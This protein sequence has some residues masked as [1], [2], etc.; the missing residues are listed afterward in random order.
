MSDITAKYE[1]VIGLEIHIQLRTE[2]KMFCSCENK[3]FATEPNTNICPVCLGLPGAMPVPNKEA[4]KAAQKIS[5]VLTGNLNDSIEFERKN[6]FYP[7]LPKGFQLTCPH[8]PVSTGGEYIFNIYNDLRVRFREIHL[9]EDTAK[10]MHK[11]GKS[12]IDFNKSG[13]PLLEIVTEPDF[14]DIDSAVEFCKEVQ[15]VAKY[16]GVSDADMEKGQM[17]L[18]ANVS[19]RLKGDSNL[20][21]YRVELKNINSFGFMK[22]AVGYELRRQV[23]ELES[24]NQLS[25]E[26]RGFN[27]KKNETFIQRSKEEAN[28]YRYFTEPDIPPIKFNKE[29]LKEITTSVTVTPNEDR[30]RLLKQKI[31]KDYIEILIKDSNLMEIFEGLTDS[32]IKC[33]KAAQIL[34]NNPTYKKMDVK[35]IIS[36]EEEKNKGR[37]DDTKELEKI[38]KDVLEQN[39]KAVDDY[40]KGN[41]NSLQYIIGQIMRVSKGKA[42]ASSLKEIVIKLIQES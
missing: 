29:W 31:N 38:V 9:E 1:P 21:N 19:A 12:H 7:D 8:Y 41:T 36:A 4:V 40:K 27:E 26:T 33:E 13:V 6:Y 34:I 16:L 11:D 3:P 20:P 2:K 18:E 42:N 10:S 25:Q 37:I 22:K 24:G 23:R 35:E 14:H 5:Y 28:D 17:R 39:K 30:K 32:G 15:L